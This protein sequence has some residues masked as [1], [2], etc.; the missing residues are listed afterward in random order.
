MKK[1]RPQTVQLTPREARELALK[2]L[3]SNKD[4]TS[5][6][7]TMAA[8]VYAA[9]HDELAEAL[10]RRKSKHSLPAA[11]WEAVAPAKRLVALH[12]QGER[13]LRS[14]TYVPGL[15]RLAPDRSRRLYAGE[16]MCSDDGTVNFGVCVPWPFGGDKCSDRYGV[17]VG[18]F[19]LFPMHDDATSYCPAFNY[20][21]RSQQQYTAAD[22]SGFLLRTARDVCKP[23]RFVLEGGN[24]QA[25]RTLAAL[26]AMGVTLVSVK[27]RPQ[28]KLIENYFNRLWTRLSLELPYSQVGRYRDDDK[29]GQEL[30][31][32][33]Q[34][35]RADPRQ[36]FPMLA[37]ALTAIETCL[38][39]LNTE[40]IESR[41][42]GTWVP[43]ERW[44]LDMAAH[45][46]ETIDAGR[47]LWLA[48]PVLAERSVV[49]GMVRVKTPGPLGQ[50]TTFHFSSPELW[51]YEG[52]RVRVAFDPLQNPAL[53]TI[54]HPAKEEVFC[55]ATC[56]DPFA[57]GDTA[58][59]VSIERQLRQMMRREYRVLLP[60]KKTGAQRI[61]LAESERRTPEAA[62]E[63]HTGELAVSGP[64][65]AP[66]TEAAR[67]PA[68]E[69]AAEPARDA[70][71]DRAAQS[72]SLRRRAARAVQDQ[73][74]Y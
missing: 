43:L 32:K 1:G 27:G 46:R 45:P 60:D 16:Q 42:Y 20:I 14:A 52:E 51:S 65:P 39:W 69:R 47:H 49:R 19:Q 30:Y 71:A 5:G 36:F 25:N 4:S 29:L 58:P 8:R 55:E 13:G 23:D 10:A 70:R 6:S 74:V 44:M 48:A 72:A 17:R 68:R 2:Y 33:C 11:V 37:T 21:V 53:A 66:E 63:I 34:T 59:E 26:R 56:V 64:A 18:R 61:Q 38:R 67:P 62:L 22:V 9:T 31:C 50:P 35:G 15:L 3:Q 7:A 57:Q 73:A 41:E 54:A 28:Q 12:R 40:P 24:W